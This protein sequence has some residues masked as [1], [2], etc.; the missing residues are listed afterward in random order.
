MLHSFLRQ[1][2]TRLDQ[3]EEDY[4]QQL[5]RAQDRINESQ[6]KENDA[7]DRMVEVQKEFEEMIV[8]NSA[9]IEEEQSKIRTQ[10]GAALMVGWV[11]F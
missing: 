11:G 1:A 3:L 6:R 5:D 8:K 9:K 10:M 7:R 2:K 4:H